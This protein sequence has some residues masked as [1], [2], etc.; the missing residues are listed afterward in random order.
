[1]AVKRDIEQ[2]AKL[3]ISSTPTY[4]VNGMLMAGGITPAVFEALAGVLRE[5]R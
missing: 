4:V 3:G 1:E 5:K 2:A